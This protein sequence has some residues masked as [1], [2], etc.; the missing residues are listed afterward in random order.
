MSGRSLSLQSG[1]WNRIPLLLER[2]S[3]IGSNKC[4][5][6]LVRLSISQ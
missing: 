4:I 6:F 5:T 1:P 3:R 2:R